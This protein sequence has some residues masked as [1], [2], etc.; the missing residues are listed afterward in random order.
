MNCTGCGKETTNPK[1][2]GM[3]CKVDYYRRIDTIPKIL[4]GE[5]NHPKTLKRFLYETRGNRCQICNQ[6]PVWNGNSLVMRL[7]HIDGNSDNN[8]PTNLRLVCPNCDSQL[9]TFCSRNIKNT[10]RNRYLRKYKSSLI[11]SAVK[12]I[13]LTREGS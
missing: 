7:D 5:C 11:S 9:E 4:R 2:C 8:D 12:S 3:Q 6:P 1:F 10:R 13:R